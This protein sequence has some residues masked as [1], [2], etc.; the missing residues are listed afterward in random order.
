MVLQTE[1]KMGDEIA[2]DDNRGQHG[3]PGRWPPPPACRPKD[4]VDAV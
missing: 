3:W 4:R 1:E 2:V